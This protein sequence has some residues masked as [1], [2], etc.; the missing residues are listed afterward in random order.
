MMEAAVVVAMEKHMA[1][2]EQHQYHQ[3]LFPT[4]MLVVVEDNTLMELHLMVWNTNLGAAAGGGAGGT[5]TPSS[6]AGKAGGGGG[7]A[8]GFQVPVLVER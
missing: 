4:S 5:E 1:E 7:G 3:V 6:V 2:S 8:G